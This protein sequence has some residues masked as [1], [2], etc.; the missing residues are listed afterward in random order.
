M[1]NEIGHGFSRIHTD[2]K[3]LH[4]DLTDKILRVFYDV[5]NELGHGFLESIYETAVMIVLTEKGI[6]AE[7][8]VDIPVW[9]RHHQ[10]GMF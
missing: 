4:Q 6:H 9:F 8:Q 5:Y 10:I 7:Q 1:W 2:K 3:M